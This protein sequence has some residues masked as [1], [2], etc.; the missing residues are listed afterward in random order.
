MPTAVSISSMKANKDRKSEYIVH[1]FAREI[2]E[3]ARMKLKS[4]QGNKFEIDIINIE[5]ED[6]FLNYT[7]ADGDLHVTPSAILKFQIPNVLKDVD[8]AIYIDGDTIVCRDLYEL[9]NMMLG[10]KP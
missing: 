10:S 9:Y 2:S 3:D 8:K 4:L 7:K 6:R 5:L 1:I